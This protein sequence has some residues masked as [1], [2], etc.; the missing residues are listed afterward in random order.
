MKT[1]GYRIRK[2]P[3]RLLLWSDGRLVE[4]FNL[5]VFLSHMRMLPSGQ[6]EEVEPVEFCDDGMIR[7]FELPNGF[8]G[9]WRIAVDKPPAAS[10]SPDQQPED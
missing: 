4:F 9:E 2:D 10:L 3:T 5:A 1:Y 6:I 7:L 8:L